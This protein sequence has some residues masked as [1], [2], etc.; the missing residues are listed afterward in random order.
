M[1]RAAVLVP[2]P[3]FHED[4]NWAYDVEAAALERGGIAVEPRPWTDPGD[5]DGFDLVLPLVAWGYHLDSAGWNALLDRLEK[6]HAV[7]VNPVT[8]LRWNSDKRYLTELAKAGAPVVPTIH[9]GALDD[10]ALA[11]AGERFGAELVIKPPVS[12]SADGTFRLGPGD[13]IPGDC[14]GRA[15]MIQPFCRSVLDEGEYSLMFFDG[16]FSHAIV[17]RPKAGDYRVQPHLGGRDEA[18][19]PPAGSLEAATAA[20]AAARPRRLCAGRPHP[21]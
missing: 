8:L 2:A 4:W 9:T 10:A 15:M 18:C 7:T 1:T 16:V 6:D 17:K 21:P 5:L 19:I 13:S 20:L 14:V 11:D 12:A 3:D